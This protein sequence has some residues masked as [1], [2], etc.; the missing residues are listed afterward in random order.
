MGRII[1][2]ALTSASTNAMATKASD[3]W[4]LEELN[5]SSAYILKRAKCGVKA[6]T[7]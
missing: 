2:N 5:H 6:T 3:S 4:Y 1:E 7:Y